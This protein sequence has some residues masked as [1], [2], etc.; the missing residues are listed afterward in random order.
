MSSDVINELGTNYSNDNET[1][2]LHWIDNRICFRF[3]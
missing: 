3:M 1:H 2:T